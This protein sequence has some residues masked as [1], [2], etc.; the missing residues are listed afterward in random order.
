MTHLTPQNF[1]NP[2]RRQQ[3]EHRVKDDLE[4]AKRQVERVA[5]KRPPPLLMVT[6]PLGSVKSGHR[7]YF[8]CLGG[9]SE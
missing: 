5:G 7:A 9:Y 2:K 3:H 8:S 1:A 6:V 4:Q